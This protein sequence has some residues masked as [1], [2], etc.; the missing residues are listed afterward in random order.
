MDRIERETFQKIFT[1]EKENLKKIENISDMQ[2]TRVAL[3]KSVYRL[4]ETRVI[5]N[6]WKRMHGIPMK[7][8][9][10]S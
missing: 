3:T 5:Y 1:E 6:N 9:I 4:L 7:R 8:K 10:R 2:K